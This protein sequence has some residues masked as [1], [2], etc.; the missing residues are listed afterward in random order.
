MIKYVVWICSECG[1]IEK[2]EYPTTRA[3]KPVCFHVDHYVIMTKMV[4]DD[5]DRS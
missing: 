5:T 3:L 4:E 1:R 2:E